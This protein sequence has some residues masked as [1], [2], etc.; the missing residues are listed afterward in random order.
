VIS[1][2]R[3]IILFFAAVLLASVGWSQTVKINFKDGTDVNYNMNN[4]QS[5]EF[6]NDNDN[7]N[8]GSNDDFSMSGDFIKITMDGKTYSDKIVDW[9]YAQID[10][11]GRDANNKPLTFTYDMRDHFDDY[12]FSFMFG[13]VHYSRKNDLLASSVGTYGCAESILSDDYYKNLTFWS[14]L[15]IDYDE[16]TW[17]SGTHEV[18]SI[19]E[20]DGRVQLEG[21]FTSNFSFNGSSRTVKGSYRITIP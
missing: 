18:K 17:N 20:V 3:R 1:V 7:N 4:V 13:V 10:P 8:Q 2:M 5:I 11:V 12:G 15:E 21:I 6:L 16:Y 19:K 9:Y 14:T